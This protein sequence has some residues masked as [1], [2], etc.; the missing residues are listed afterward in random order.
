MPARVDKLLLDL[1]VLCICLRWHLHLTE[2]LR[3]RPKVA[4]VSLSGRHATH[5]QICC[6]LMWLEQACSQLQIAARTVGA[7]FHS[8][9][10][11]LT[12]I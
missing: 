6:S 2:R 1:P 12:A 11:Q 5:R 10:G 4:G 7:A 8:L 3:G 9:Q